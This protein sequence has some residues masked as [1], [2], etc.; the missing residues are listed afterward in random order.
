MPASRIGCGM[1][2]RVVRGVEIVEEGN[3]A[4]LGETRMT[5]GVAACNCNALSR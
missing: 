5:S 2:R 4:I 3:E 1:A